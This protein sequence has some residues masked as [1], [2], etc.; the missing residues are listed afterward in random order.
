[1]K[2]FKQLLEELEGVAEGMFGLSAKE[3]GTIMNITS[4][5]SDTPGMW[6]H[7]AQTFT[8]AG[9]KELTKLLKNNAK[10]IKYALTLTSDDYE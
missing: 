1:M 2:T 6:D 5:L 9:K 10:H 8:D 7:K 3:K 4:D